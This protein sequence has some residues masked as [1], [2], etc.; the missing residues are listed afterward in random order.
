MLA[1]GGLGLGVLSGGLLVGRAGAQQPP[2]PVAAARYQYK[3][4]T[5]LPMQMYKPES[6]AALN[7]EG[8]DGWRLLDGLSGQNHLS[9]ADQYCF[10]REVR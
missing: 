9:G 3:C 6:L 1:L 2:A 5:G 10:V 7:R 4:V 8:A